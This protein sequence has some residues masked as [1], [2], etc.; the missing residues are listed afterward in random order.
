ML[1]LPTETDEDLQGICDICEKIRAVYARKKRQK[2]LRISV[3]AA[4]FVP[5]PF[6]PFQWERQADEAEVAYK[7]DYLIK[8]LPRGV[9]FS[10]SAYYPSL[11]EAVLARGDRAL[12]KVILS[13]Y[14]NGCTFDGWDNLF[15]K[16][17]GKSL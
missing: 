2:A 16:R 10:W 12:G 5:K 17:A 9:K 7:Q 3:S 1:G 13:A 6:T 15:L 8:H 4:T 11:L 14:K